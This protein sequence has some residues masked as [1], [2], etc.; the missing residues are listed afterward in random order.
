MNLLSVNLL[1]EEFKSL[2]K[3]EEPIIFEESPSNVFDPICFVGLNGSGKSHLMEFIAESFMHCEFYLRNEK[4]IS[5]S[6]NPLF[7]ELIYSLNAG[8]KKEVVKVRRDKKTKIDFLRL[9]DKEEFENVDLNYNLI[10]KRIVGYS[11]GLNETLSAPFLEINADFSQ[12]LST[13]A[14]TKENYND[15]VD[16]VRMTYLD[17]ST[18]L[19]LVIINLIYQPD[20]SKLASY[21][22]LQK[23]KHFSIEIDRNIRVKVNTNA[24]LDGIIDDLGKCAYSKNINEDNSFY[25]F[26]FNV[27]E[28]LKTAINEVFGGP[29]LFF[30]SLILLNHLNFLAIPPK[31]MTWLRNKR[32]E[33]KIIGSPVIPDFQKFFK[34]SNVIFENEN[35]IEMG[36]E[37]LSDGEHQLFQTLGSLNIIDETD[38]L[39]LFDEPDTHY[40]PE[41][42]SQLFLEYSNVSKARNQEIIVSSH[43]PFIIS[44]VRSEMVYHFEKNRKPL[45]E[46]P[47]FETYGCS[48]DT[49]LRRL[50]KKTTMV[51][52]LPYKEMEELAEK[53][54]EEILSKIDNY[55]ESH[56]KAMLYKRLIELK[57]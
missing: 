9:N 12:K 16:P 49:I 34:I 51:P 38:T 3:F 29:M 37:G 45:I 6:K 23:L 42:R 14:N 55:G 18:N 7:F 53:G 35:G 32:K 33:G 56:P 22:H 57:K 27:D 50:F 26:N 43:S 52:L 39:F 40:N 20:E 41:W 13:A 15:I 44:S 48:I 24:Q 8:S 25:S 19:I 2:K 54:Y 4:I 28:S 11:S 5:E 1:S 21:C 30:D 10:P 47:R 17:S 31:Q 36:Y 46:K